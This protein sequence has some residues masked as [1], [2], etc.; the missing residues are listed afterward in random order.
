MA[1]RKK[2]PDELKVVRG[3]FRKDRVNPD[4]PAPVSDAPKA[5]EFLSVRARQIFEGLV[6]KI[7]AMGYASDSHTEMLALC[8]MRLEEVET[9][10][11]TIRIE[12]S[13]YE[14]TNQGGDPVF[15]ARPE[16][17]LR[18]QAMRHAQ[19]ILAEFGLSPASKG[20]VSVK[21][22]KKQNR[23]ADLGGAKKAV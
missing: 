10:T 12:G 11:E 2:T 16:V 9:Y 14:T 17:G 20:K 18:S 1:G 23:W 15:K 19:S 8:A 6:E 7:S 5:P 13:V 22:D 21:Q 4:A 3:T